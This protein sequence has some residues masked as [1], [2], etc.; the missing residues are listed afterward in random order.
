M[1]GRGAG[2]ERQHPV[3]KSVLFFIYHL[4]R[5]RQRPSI[6]YTFKNQNKL[7]PTPRHTT[8]SHTAS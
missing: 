8:G 4:Q 3:K 7:N 2:G 5:M 6:K 1:G